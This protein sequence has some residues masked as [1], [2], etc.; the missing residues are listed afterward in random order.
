[1]TQKPFHETHPH[2]KEFT[3]FIDMLN[4]E[5]DRG[6][7]LI[8]TGYLEEQLKQTLLAYFIEEKSVVSLVEGGNAPLGTFSARITSCYALG[9]INEDELHDLNQIRRIRNEFAHGI[10]VSFEIQSTIDRCKTLRFKAGDYD[11]EKLGEIRVPS[12][13]Q[14]RTAA[15]A[16]ILNLVNRPHYVSQ[17][18]LKTKAWKY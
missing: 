3:A 18:R 7:V 15:T 8:S 5:S 12:S 2:L 1:M 6:A 13:G 9:L 11:S 14:F 10:H 16:L 4:K 17:G